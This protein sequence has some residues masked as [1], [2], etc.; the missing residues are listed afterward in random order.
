[1]ESQNI[2][3]NRSLVIRSKANSIKNPLVQH[4]SPL[5]ATIF[6]FTENS[7]G[8]KVESVDWEN[9]VLAKIS[10][11]KNISVELINRHFNMSMGVG[12][13]H[14]NADITGISLKIC[15]SEVNGNWKLEGNTPV[16]WDFG[17]LDGDK[18]AQFINSSFKS[19]GIVVKG[20]RDLHIEEC[21]FKND[22]MLIQGLTYFYI[23]QTVFD[24]ASSS[25]II[26][27]TFSD[28]VLLIHSSN[29][30]IINC[31][32]SNNK[33][34]VMYLSNSTISIEKTTFIN[35]TFIGNGNL[36]SGNAFLAANLSNVSLSRVT[37]FQNENYTFLIDCQGSNME[38]ENSSISSNKIASL[39]FCLKKASFRKSKLI[40]N[41]V[42]SAI[43]GPRLF[44]QSCSFENNTVMGSLII[45]L[46]RKHFT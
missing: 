31:T 1:M 29:A 2:A 28:P 35:N 43:A 33:K 30:S 41:S 44:I 36:Y 16:T 46:T 8:M 17:T 34:S 18:N 39:F 32:F 14:F 6:I 7:T 9:I 40:N 4:L 13:I 27:D 24:V 26:Q 10:H 20:L 3:F 38:I 15:D 21:F 25:Y 11:T 12:F 22:A 5:I 45:V 37:F 19:V 42:A 23:G